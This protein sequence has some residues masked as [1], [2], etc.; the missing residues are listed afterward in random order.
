[1]T[2]VTLIIVTF[3][4][5]YNYNTIHLGGVAKPDRDTI[6]ELQTTNETP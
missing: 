6:I 2:T 4:T 5:P 3:V 1:M